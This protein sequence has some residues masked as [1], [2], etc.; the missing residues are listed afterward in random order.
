MT[1]K[2]TEDMAAPGFQYLEAS[3]ERYR[4]LKETFFCLQICLYRKIDLCRLK[5]ASII[6]VAH[7]GIPLMHRQSLTAAEDVG[8]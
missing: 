2:Y 1:T 3:S 5:E 8:F 7:F 6:A 4:F